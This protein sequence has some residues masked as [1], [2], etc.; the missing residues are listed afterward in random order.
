MSNFFQWHW[1][2]GPN[3]SRWCWITT[4]GLAVR[5]VDGGLEKQRIH[6]IWPSWPARFET[7]RWKQPVCESWMA[8][9]WRSVRPTGS[10]RA[11]AHDSECRRVQVVRSARRRELYDIAPS[12][13]LSAEERDRIEVG[14]PG[15]GLLVTADGRVWVNL[16]GH[17]SPKSKPW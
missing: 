2:F 13:G 15:R 1:R 17:T 9:C 5:P 4:H 6:A 8:T 10:A 14:R 16:Y 11:S 12:L 3:G 7:A